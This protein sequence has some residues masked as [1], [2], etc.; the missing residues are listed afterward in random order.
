M[1]M[2]HDVPDQGN[3]WRLD[4]R[5]VRYRL[6]LYEKRIVEL[7]KVTGKMRFDYGQLHGRVMTWVVVISL[8]LGSIAS[9]GTAWAL[10]HAEDKRVATL[11]EELL[12][13]MRDQQAQR[14]DK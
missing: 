11:I 6:G 10:K 9:A 2:D 7:E 14:G 3:G 13:T 1:A 12:T 8:I 5:E 4:E